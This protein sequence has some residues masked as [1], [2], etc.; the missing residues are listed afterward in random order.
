MLPSERAGGGCGGRSA[1]SQAIVLVGTC[2][3]RGPLHNPSTQLTAFA[4]AHLALLP[5]LGDLE[6]KLL[7]AESV[8]ARMEKELSD[9]RA[10]VD[11]SQA[12]ERGGRGKG[13]AGARGWVGAGRESKACAPAPAALLQGSANAQL[14]QW[15]SLADEREERLAA[16]ASTL[17]Q[18]QAELRA[19][20]AAHEVALADLRGKHEQVGAS[21]AHQPDERG[22]RESAACC[23]CL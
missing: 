15:K 4:T 23:Y 1:L 18:A 8:R 13:G 19:A 3:V 10:L 7:A 21:R 12:S 11:A 17:Q 14:S 6:S 9:A 16:Q 2:E 5:R 20:Q 22:G